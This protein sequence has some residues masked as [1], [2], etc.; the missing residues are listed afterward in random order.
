MTPLTIAYCTG[1]SDPKLNWFVDSLADQCDG[2]Q[3]RAIQL[4]I[5]DGRLWDR[6]MPLGAT[7]P[8]GTKIRFT[9]PIFHDLD[10]RLEVE[11]IVNNRFEVIHTPPLPCT[12][13]GPFRLTKKD[14]FCASNTR[15]T[16]FC[17]A[18]HG[19]IAFCDDL[20]VLSPLWLGQV[21]HAAARGYAVA[22]CYKKLKKM[23]VEDG[24][25]TSFEEFPEGVDSRWNHGSDQGIV[26]WEGSI[27][28][29]SFGV[30]LEDALAIDGFEMACCG[31]GNEDSD[32][33][34]RL[35]RSGPPI[36]LNRNMATSES[37]EDHHNQTFKDQ[38][39]RDRKLV[40]RDRLPA[41]YD[42]YRMPSVKERYYSDHVLVNRVLNEARTQPITPSNL[43]AIRQQF[44]EDGTVTIPGEP[45]A[46]WRD[47]TPLRDL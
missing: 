32:F 14:W 39:T 25:L 9:D 1:R 43:R 4:L 8:P 41:A 22:G 6:R 38:A 15:N 23:V 30:L 18:R 24:R 31:S 12:M 7:C 20:S 28:G 46:D 35:R 27:F 40:S 16:A 26:P 21:L 36:F 47:G 45:A 33:S 11:Q 17:I 34:I 19:Y 2:D 37:E 42:S 3:R 10:R 44:L 5:I 13:Q 29:C